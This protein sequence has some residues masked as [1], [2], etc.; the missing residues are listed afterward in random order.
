MLMMTKYFNI[1]Y[2]IHQEKRYASNTSNKAADNDNHNVE[3]ETFFD[4][5]QDYSTLKHYI[6]PYLTL[7]G[8]RLKSTTGSVK[9]IEILIPGCGNSS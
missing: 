7:A 9:D 5:Y 4:W 1:V 6:E 2:R 3:E 8:R